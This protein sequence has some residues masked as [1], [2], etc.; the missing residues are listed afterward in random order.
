VPVQSRSK[1]KEVQFYLDRSQE[2]LITTLKSIIGNPRMSDD[3]QFS[4][5]RTL[6]QHHRQIAELIGQRLY[7]GERQGYELAGVPLPPHLAR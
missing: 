6:E 4:C 3:E 7:D 2:A 1:E 5:L